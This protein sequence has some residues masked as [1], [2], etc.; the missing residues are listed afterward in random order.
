MSPLYNAS[1]TLQYMAD[2]D[3]AAGND[4]LAGLHAARDAFYKGDIAR[5]IVRFQQREGGYLSMQDLAEYHSPI[6]PTVQQ[7]W[8]GQTVITC[9]PWC[10]GPALLEALALLEH[11]GIAGL[12]HNAAT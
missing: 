6:E 2:Q 9:G 8:R 3:R 5:E 11:V 1:R 12:A 4:R 10:Q 7:N